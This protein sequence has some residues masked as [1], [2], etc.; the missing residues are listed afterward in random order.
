M[1]RIF[2]IQQERLYQWDT[3][4]RLLQA[5]PVL[6]HPAE[7]VERLQQH[8]QELDA[9]QDLFDKLQ[10]LPQTTPQDHWIWQQTMVALLQK[11]LQQEHEAY[12]TINDRPVKRAR[13]AVIDR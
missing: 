1:D 12:L 10:T 3:V 6:G 8:L 4:Y 9:H 13:Y 5:L 11:T 7:A 2:A